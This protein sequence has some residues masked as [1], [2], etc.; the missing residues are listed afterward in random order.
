MLWIISLSSSGPIWTMRSER[1]CPKHS[2]R[3]MVSFIETAL[4]VYAL[5]RA[6]MSSPS[7]SYCL[8]R[9]L[10]IIRTSSGFWMNDSWA[11][12]MVVCEISSCSVPEDY[13]HYNVSNA[14]GSAQV[15]STDAFNSAIFLFFLTG[16]SL[17]FLSSCGSSSTSTFFSRNFFTFSNK[18]TNRPRR[19]LS[20]SASSSS[21]SIWTP[22][23][24]FNLETVP[25]C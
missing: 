13:I 4:I 24:S 2:S 17:G 14:V 12:W 6:R 5:G 10:N 20:T 7:P 22:E 23:W 19:E 3:S 18:R 8:W 9:R 25:Q 1:I 16:T 11:Q 21:S 15:Y